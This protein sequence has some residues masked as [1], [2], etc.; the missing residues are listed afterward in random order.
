MARS[1]CC[2]AQTEHCAVCKNLYCTEC[3]EGCTC[4][5]SADSSEEINFSEDE[6]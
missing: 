5:D 4:S 6:G 2:G 3:F 1:E